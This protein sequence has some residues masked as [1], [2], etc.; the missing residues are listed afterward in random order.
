MWKFLE[1]RYGK[2]KTIDGQ[3][4]VYDHVFVLIL[5]KSIKLDRN[6]LP[7][8][9]GIADSE[10]GYKG[11]LYFKNNSTNS[12]YTSANDRKSLYFPLGKS[13]FLDIERCE[14]VTVDY[15]FKRVKF[16]IV[17]NVYEKQRIYV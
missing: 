8:H 13:Y 15:L 17:K 5:S 14:E 6:N 16:E 12:H 9:I 7:E 11:E 2:R 4:R 10:K 3:F 1:K